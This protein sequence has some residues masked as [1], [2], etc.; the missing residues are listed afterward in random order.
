MSTEAIIII[1]AV[2]A[3]VAVT[4]FLVFRQRAKVDIKGPWGSGLHVDASNEPSPTNPA[5][6]VKDATSASGG[7]RARDE[8][9]RGAD[10]QR[11]QV[12]KD[13]EVSSRPPGGTDPKA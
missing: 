1:I 5:V 12:E 10:V 3:L 9:G 6:V 2:F 13:I 7:L 4:A 11:V 8:T